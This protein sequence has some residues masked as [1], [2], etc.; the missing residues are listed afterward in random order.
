MLAL[1]KIG[2]CIPSSCSKEDVHAG[3]TSAW[4]AVVSDSGLEIFAD[5]CYSKDENI[6]LDEADWVMIVILC[7]F[8]FTVAFST[9]VDIGG[10]VFNVKQLKSS[11]WS[12][13]LRGFSA[14]SNT[15]KIFSTGK[16]SQDSLTCINGIR[17][18]S[19][20][21]V[22]ISHGYSQFGSS[23]PVNNLL[24]LADGKGPVYGNLAFQAILNGFPSVDSFFFI[25]ATLLA[26]ITL[27]ELDKTN[28][29]NVQFW[30]MYYVHRY[31][32]LTGVYALVIGITA[33]LIKFFAVGPYSI[34][35]EYEIKNCKKDWWT[36]ILY[37]NNL[38]WV[39][40]TQPMCMPVS[41]Y[42]ANDMQFFLISPLIIYPLWKYP[43]FGLGAGFLW[44]VAGTVIPMVIVYINDFPLSVSFMTME[45]FAYFSDVYVVPWCRFQPYIMGLMFGWLLH[46][47]RSQPKLK[48]NPFI[49]TWI[50]AAIG[51]AGAAVV[52]CL[53]PFQIELAEAGN[54]G[55][56]GNLATRV[57]YN[58]LHRLAWSVCLGWVILACVKGA[59]GPIN[60][61][62]SWHAWIPLARL[63]YCIYLVHYTLISYLVG[64]PSF[65]VSFSHPLGV[66]WVLAILSLSIFVAYVAVIFLEAPIVALEKILFQT[67][68]G[69][70]KKGGMTE[71]IPSE[72]SPT[73]QEQ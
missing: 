21:W 44:M 25:G 61:I 53:Y 66:F 10:N 70:G 45:N 56:V 51:A 30:I 69:T 5:N 43:R 57:V 22:L 33:T 52:Y 67:I 48:L 65:S 9:L 71:K 27:R 17:F 46:R 42:L 32:R 1:G 72:K 58:G 55:L 4:E 73:I 31:I 64:L 11:P 8:G 37:I 49:I 68:L 7:L 47:M 20:T 29:G 26:F 54:I 60:Q 34:L 18:L 12:Q 50:W 13:T 41:W 24:Y 19:M 62:L 63:S 35:V 2:R 16:I 23:L 6:N 38:K 15:V 36:N 59:G 3:L 14:Y 39:S 40:D 28:G